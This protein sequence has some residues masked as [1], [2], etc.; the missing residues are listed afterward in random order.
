MLTIKSYYVNYKI[1]QVSMVVQ[2]GIWNL[3]TLI[4]SILRGENVLEDYG[5]YQIPLTT[6]LFIV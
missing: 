4:N 5:A 2:C 3:M 1:I 6:Y